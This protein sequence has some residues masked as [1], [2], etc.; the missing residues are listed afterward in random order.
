L[1]IPVLPS[2]VDC[3]AVLNVLKIPNRVFASVGESL[4]IGWFLVCFV[5]I[6]WVIE[7]I[8]G[9]ILLGI[10][11]LGFLVGRLIYRNLCPAPLIHPRIEPSAIGPSTVH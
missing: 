9:T 10:A 11:V 6:D 4:G 2:G 8:A 3:G 1:T 5:T 7:L